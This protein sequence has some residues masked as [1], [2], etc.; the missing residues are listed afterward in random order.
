MEKDR[1][2]SF[3]IS[4]P[5]GS[6]V[7]IIVLILL[8]VGAFFF[9]SLSEKVK[10]LEG[11]G[12]VNV[13]N[14]Q[15]VGVGG[16]QGAAG[17]AV[18]QPQP[19]APTAGP[20]PKVEKDEHIRGNANAKLALIE[21]SDLE[22]PF[23]KS[24][25]PTVQKVL[26]TYKNDVMWV[27]RHYPLGFHAN[28]QKEAEATECAAELGGNDAFWKYVDAIYERTTSNGIGFAL[29][30]LVPL[31]KE[32]GL[33]DQKFKEC[34][35]TGK[36]T[37]KI[38]DQMNAGTAAGVSGTPGSFVLNVKTGESQIVSGA[39]PFEQVKTTIDAMLK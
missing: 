38:T 36:Y 22:C 7:Q 10:I 24:F 39:V 29:D 27:Y 30:A 16:G 31:A 12:T 5:T 15:P 34:L 2:D 1:K 20:V 8:I 6:P 32:Q 25:H 37:K 14:G 17:N 26:D 35:D 3:T 21:Y 13:A 11:K 19:P 9:G 23:C 4:L 18:G 33:N 28:A